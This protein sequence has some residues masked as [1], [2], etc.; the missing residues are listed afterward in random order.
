M[1]IKH[2]REIP[3]GSPAAGALTTRGIWKFCDFDQ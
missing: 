1:S 3:M 2:L